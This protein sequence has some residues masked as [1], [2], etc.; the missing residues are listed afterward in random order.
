MTAER[1][2]VAG[3]GLRACLKRWRLVKP[4]ERREVIW[5][6]RDEARQSDQWAKDEPW[7][8][9]RH[10]ADARAMRAAVRL[11]RAAGATK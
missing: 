4:A 5:F 2:D 10:R 11:L 6:F 1:R 3:G 7:D 9:A 8:A